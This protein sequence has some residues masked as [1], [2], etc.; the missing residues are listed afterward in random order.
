MQQLWQSIWYADQS[1]RTFDFTETLLSKRISNSLGFV[2]QCQKTRRCFL[3]PFLNFCRAFDL[4]DYKIRIAKLFAA[5][6]TGNFFSTVKSYLNNRTQFVKIASI[7]SST[8]PIISRVPQGSNLAPTLFLFINDLLTSPLNCK[9][10]VYAD[11]TTFS[12]S[13]HNPT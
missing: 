13:H 5:G 2:S 6:I 11:G 3:I 7:L 4:V 1:E 12:L 8:R 10:Y 9:A